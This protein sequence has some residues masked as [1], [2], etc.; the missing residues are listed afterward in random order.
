MMKKDNIEQQLFL[1]FVS[2]LPKLQGFLGSEKSLNK[3]ETQ[4]ELTARKVLS[5]FGSR[6]QDL[7]DKNGY[8]GVKVHLLR[9][10]WNSPTHSI[11]QAID[12]FHINLVCVGR[13][14][15]G[16]LKKLFLGSTSKTVLEEVDCNCLI[17]KK[18]FDEMKE[19]ELKEDI[20]EAK[21][22]RLFTK[23][24]ITDV[25]PFASY[26]ERF[27]E[28]PQETE[29]N[30][31][32]EVKHEKNLKEKQLEREDKEK[33][34]PEEQGEEKEKSGSDLEKKESKVSDV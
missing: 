31:K 29:V 28:E 5:F 8:T 12:R 26:Q 27:F 17:I 25:S 16:F 33:L 4:S 23:D 11:S 19:G 24:K 30:R 32:P 2:V 1:L 3:L 7:L 20:S 15:N 6:A 14:G 18:P 9:A 10:K 21:T 22:D 13:G 34:N